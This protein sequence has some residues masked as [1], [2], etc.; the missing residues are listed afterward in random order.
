MCSGGAAAGS[1][2]S[3]RAAR[4]AQRRSKC[5][6]CGNVPESGDMTCA[7]E[8]RRWKRPRPVKT[9]PAKRWKT[10]STKEAHEAKAT[11]DQREA[12]AAARTMRVV[13][14]KRGLGP[15][16]RA[17]DAPDDEFDPHDVL[18]VPK[19]ASLELIRAAHEG[20]KR[21]RD[22]KLAVDFGG[23]ELQAYFGGQDRR[24]SIELFQLLTR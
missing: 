10:T 20:P 14:A 23:A 21:N 9:P 4:H 6:V 8:C 13:N 1:K 7:S 19:G 17:A 16:D 3:A 12:R 2:A 5:R 15:G 18:G 11:R 22:P 24:L